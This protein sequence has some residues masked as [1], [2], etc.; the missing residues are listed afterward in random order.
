MGEDGRETADAQWVWIYV[1]LVLQ[2]YPVRLAVLGT[3]KPT[4]I[5]TCRREQ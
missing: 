3:L 2:S 4:P 1:T 5:T